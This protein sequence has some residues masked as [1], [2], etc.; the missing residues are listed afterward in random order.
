MRSADLNDAEMASLHRPLHENDTPRPLRI[1]RQEDESHVPSLQPSRH[2]S[3]TNY[4]PHA[5]GK[6]QYDWKL[7]EE[8]LGG[9]R[10]R[11]DAYAN[12][13]GLAYPRHSGALASYA[14]SRP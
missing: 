3:Y 14:S 8:R 7:E 5:D 1:R 12:E 10:Q 11:A 13:Q 9:L 6:R 2:A 4:E